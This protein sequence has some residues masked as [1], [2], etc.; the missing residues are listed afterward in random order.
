MA[1][2]SPAPTMFTKNGSGCAPSPRQ[3][4]DGV[5]GSCQC[6]VVFIQSHA[7]TIAPDKTALLETGQPTT[8]I[9][10]G[11]HRSER[12]PTSAPGTLVRPRS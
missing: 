2:A 12:G 5:R 7:W 8:R 4:R 6:A 9:C 1:I 10:D 3:S 11:S